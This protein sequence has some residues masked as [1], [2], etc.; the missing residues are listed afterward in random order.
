MMEQGEAVAARV[1]AEL[2]PTLA[3]AALSRYVRVFDPGIFEPTASSDDERGWNGPRPSADDE[4]EI[5]GYLIRARTADAWDA[6]VGLLVALSGQRPR[7]FHALM[8][9]CRDLSNSTPEQDGLHNLLLEPEQALHDIA[10][11]REHR[12]VQQG[13]LSADD[14]RAFLKLARQPRQGQSTNPIAAAYFRDLDEAIA[15]TSERPPDDRGA[16]VSSIDIAVSID[17]ITEVMAEA[18][19][20]RTQPRALLGPGTAETTCLMPIEP[21]MEYVVATNPAAYR[22]RNQELTFLAN[23]LLAGCSVYGRAFTIQEAWDAAVGICNVGLD[24]GPLPDAFLVEHDLIGEFEW[25][26]RLLHERVSVFVTDALIAVLAEVR[27]VDADIQRDLDGLRRNLMRE[28][29][30]GMPF[31]A[32]ESLEVLSI[33]DTPTWACLC[34]LLSECPVAP[35]ALSAILERRTSAISATAFACFTTRAQIGRVADLAGRLR[36]LLLH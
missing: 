24:R 5:G 27:T 20:E 8:Q 2:D 3:I 34:G 18:A 31:R 13:Y 25:G 10:L 1:I 22:L 7:V 23:A 12:R 14:A 32:A 21:L 26:W 9:G 11:E 29:T 6:I 19:I 28:R 4:C 35:D 15:S 16:A 33:L 17:A 30:A 36:D